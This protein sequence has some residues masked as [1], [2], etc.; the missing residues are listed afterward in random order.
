PGYEAVAKEL[1]D[2]TGDGRVGFAPTAGEPRE[3]DEE[4]DEDDEE[5]EED[6]EADDEAEAADDTKKVE[7]D[8]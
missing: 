8:A 5:D 2:A 6:D 3:A 4:E 7:S 1:A